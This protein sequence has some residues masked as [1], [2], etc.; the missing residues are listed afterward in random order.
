M[1]TFLV[2]L[3]FL[4]ST[5][6]QAAQKVVIGIASNFTAMSDNMWNPYA[7]YFRNAV[8]LALSD[9]QSVLQKS[10]VEVELLELDYGNDKVAA[11]KVALDAVNSKAIAVI[12][13][14]YSSEV[15]LASEI[16]NQNKL[17]LLSP[18][19]TADRIGTL[20]RY[21]R[22]CSFNDSFQGK[23]LA[24]TA[25]EENISTAGIVSIADCAYCQSLRNAFKEHFESQGGKIVLD[26]SFLE[27]E[28]QSTTSILK[29]KEALKARALDAV[30]LPNYERV[31]S[32]LIST[33]YDNGIRP[34]VWLGGD[35]WGMMSDLFLQIVGKR[36]IE[37]LA[38]A[39]WHKDIGTP[40]TTEFLKRF[41]KKYGKDPNDVAAISYDAMK[42]LLTAVSKAEK[43]DRSGVLAAVEKIERFDGITGT[44]VYTGEARSPSKDAVLM[45]LKNGKVAL[46]KKITH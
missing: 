20:G 22:T 4:L 12:G 42:L 11:R 28:I 43:K 18:S 25:R 19:T 33:L 39:H 46:V 35:G 31:S 16:F 23:L 21:I 6:L 3:I 41:S 32:S 8:N 14:P 1:K 17:L 15:L 34:K 26:E 30:F 40:G 38:I 2:L 10:G 36:P 13:Y 5:S 7:N 24:R 9:M 37:G 27:N 44:M 45:R 29:I